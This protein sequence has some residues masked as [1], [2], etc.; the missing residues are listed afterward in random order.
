MFKVDTDTGELVAIQPRR[1]CTLKSASAPTD[2]PTTRP[3]RP[4]RAIVDD[5][6]ADA[7]VLGAQP[8]GQIA[9]PFNRAKLADGTTENRGGESTLG[10]LVAEVQRWA[11]DAE[12]GSAQIAF[13]NPGGLRAGHGRHGT[14][15]T[16]GR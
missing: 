3:T 5:A 1:S 10:N 7:D 11:T 8:L 12:S 16:R 13:M 4:R 14:A 6:V 9:G 15:R 2:A